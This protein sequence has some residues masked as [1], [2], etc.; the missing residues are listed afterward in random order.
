M[1]IIEFRTLYTS[2]TMALN[3]HTVKRNKATIGRKRE[4]RRGKRYRREREREEKR[5]SSFTHLFQCSLEIR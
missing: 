5:V 1:A 4:K 3:V 2:D